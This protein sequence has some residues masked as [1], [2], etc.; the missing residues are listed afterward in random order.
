[1]TLEDWVIKGE[2]IM[3]QL[4]K[5]KIMSKENTD[6]FIEIIKALDRIGHEV[7]EIAYAL[8]ECRQSPVIKITVGM[9]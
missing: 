6:E 1:M 9:R 2:K 3:H 5:E 7:L 8:E 4:S